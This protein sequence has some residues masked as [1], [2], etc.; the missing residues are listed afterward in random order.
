MSRRVPRYAQGEKAMHISR[1][2]VEA[3]LK[4]YFQIDGTLTPEK[5]LRMGGVLFLVLLVINAVLLPLCNF[6][7]PVTNNVS[8]ALP[9]GATIVVIVSAVSLIIR[10]LQ[11]SGHSRLWAL[12][13]LVL[14]F[15]IILLIVLYF[16]PS[17]PKAHSGFSSGFS[18]D[19]RSGS[20]RPGSGEHGPSASEVHSS[21][22]AVVKRGASGSADSVDD[23]RPKLPRN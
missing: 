14:G 6:V 17:R 9:A 21:A 5:Y 23:T 3:F 7:A 16:L 18:S 13:L 22:G 11:D 4:P 10:R 1:E 20:S 12:L 8:L 19:F 2:Q 15:N